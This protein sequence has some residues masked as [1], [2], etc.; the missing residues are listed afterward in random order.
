MPLNE[1]IYRLRTEKGMS[2]GDLADAL[3]VSRQSVSKWET[4][5]A[6]PDLDKLVKLSALFGVTLDELVKGEVPTAEPP[7]QS[8]PQVIYVERQEPPLPRRKIVGFALFGLA[9]LTVLLCTVLGGMLAGVLF[10]FPFWACGAVC[11]LLDKRVG[12]W[13][14]WVLFFLLDVYLRFATGISWGGI[15]SLIRSFAYAGRIQWIACVVMTVSITTLVV[16]TVRAFRDKVLKPTRAAKLRMWI[17]LAVLAVAFAL[18]WGYA[19]FMQKMA[20]DGQSLYTVARVSQVLGTVTQWT[21]APILCRL[22]IDLLAMRRWKP[23]QE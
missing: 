14:C 16:C 17:L 8:E 6:T 21:K 1:T 19:L 15:F 18:P 4:G 11:F 13:C 10:S 12:L 20:T 5:G 22:A 23:Q 2:Q 7:S 9:I 3:E